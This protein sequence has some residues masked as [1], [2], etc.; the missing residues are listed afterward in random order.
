[1]ARI[2]PEDES[3]PGVPLGARQRMGAH[4]AGRVAVGAAGGS[5]REI[6]T[7][8]RYTATA[9]VV[10]FSTIYRMHSSELLLSRSN[11]AFISPDNGT[12]T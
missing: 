4:G 12:G 10:V 11:M 1:V 8:E 9:F 5:S 2:A 7:A 6:A 3:A